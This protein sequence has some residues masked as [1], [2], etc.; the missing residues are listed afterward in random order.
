[1]LMC[2]LSAILKHM[3]THIH[4]H[5]YSAFTL[6]CPLVVMAFCDCLF[7]LADN[8]LL[9][10]ITS[11]FRII[12]NYP[13]MQHLLI[14]RVCIHDCLLMTLV[15]VNTKGKLCEK[16]KT[17]ITYSNDVPHVRSLSQQS[18]LLHLFNN[19]KTFK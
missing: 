15:A 4:L 10:L 18:L 3:F 17:L 14:I 19:L 2:V 9:K 13:E 8:S 7:Y 6:Q 5:K 11:D 1:M 16:C 12:S